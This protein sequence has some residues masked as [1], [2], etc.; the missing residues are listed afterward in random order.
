MVKQLLTGLAG[1]CIRFTFQAGARAA[2]QCVLH[3]VIH[4]HRVLRLAKLTCLLTILLALCLLA[5]LLALLT[6]LLALLTV[7]LSPLT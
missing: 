4:G 3:V 5:K 6:V 7:L 2:K 1:C